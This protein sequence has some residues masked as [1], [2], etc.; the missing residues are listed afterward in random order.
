M[1]S[2]SVA[3]EFEAVA[4]SGLQSTTIGVECFESHFFFNASG[5]L[6]KLLAHTVNKDLSRASFQCNDGPLALLCISSHTKLLQ[7]S[8]GFSTPVDFPRGFFSKEKDSLLSSFLKLKLLL[9]DFTNRCDDSKG[10]G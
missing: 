4:P 7:N 6:L 10:G 3:N 2:K 8:L 5:R 9:T 1:V